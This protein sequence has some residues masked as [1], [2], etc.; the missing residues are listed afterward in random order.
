MITTHSSST[1]RSW[2]VDR[3]DRVPGGQIEMSAGG[4]G[5]IA[6]HP[7][8]VAEQGH[9][10]LQA[11]LLADL[12]QEEHA[13]RERLDLHGRIQELMN[14]KSDWLKERI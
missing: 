8:A 6:F 9:Y 10:P 13:D 5:R 14:E 2:S 12:G 3:V 1:Q 7:A 11:E 4:H